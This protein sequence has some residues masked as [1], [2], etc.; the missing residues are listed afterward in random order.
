MIGMLVRMGSID[1]F[2][3][4]SNR[5][6]SEYPPVKSKNTIDLSKTVVMAFGRR[7]ASRKAAVF[8]TA[9]QN[10]FFLKDSAKIGII[11][12]GSQNCAGIQIALSE[13]YNTV[14]VKNYAE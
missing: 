12:H 2:D 3:G 13:L 8:L 10:R 6:E 14:E 7:N 11:L 4:S 5:G 9:S 1:F